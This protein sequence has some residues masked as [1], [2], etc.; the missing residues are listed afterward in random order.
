MKKLILPLI[1][2][3]IILKIVIFSAV[4]FILGVSYILYIGLKC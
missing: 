3:K 2:K 1:I 4:A